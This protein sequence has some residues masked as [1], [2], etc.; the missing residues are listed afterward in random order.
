MVVPA[1]RSPLILYSVNT[2]LA[3]GINEQYYSGTHFV[4]CTDVFDARRHGAYMFGSRVPPSSCPCE[5][6]FDL[7][8]SVQRNDFHSAK[9]Q[10]VKKA[11][12]RGAGVQL[13]LGRITSTL[14]EFLE[15][16]SVFR[17]LP[18]G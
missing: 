6:Y 10:A 1:N 13:D 5:I 17:Q 7:L 18:G 4:W 14:C 3:W 15:W 11:V 12:R 16:K 2:R 9:I 8:R